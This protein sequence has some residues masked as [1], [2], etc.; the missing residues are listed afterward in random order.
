MDRKS[1]FF[2]RERAAMTSSRTIPDPSFYIFDSSRAAMNPK[3]AA[4]DP[5]REAMDSRKHIMESHSFIRSRQRTVDDSRWYF[6][7]P[8]RAARVPATTT[9][10]G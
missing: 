10:E 2:D 6:L 7:A 8:S 1:F 4:V 3:R 9:C 5:E